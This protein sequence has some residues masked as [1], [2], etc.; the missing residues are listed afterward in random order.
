MEIIEDAAGVRGRET[1]PR[2][3]PLASPV[4]GGELLIKVPGGVAWYIQSM[5]FQFATSAVVA[6]R[7]VTL[8]FGDGSAL[9]ERAPAQVTQA[10]SGNTIYTAATGLGVVQ[11]FGSTQTIALPTPAIPL[12]GGFQITTATS[13]IDVGDQY[14]NIVLYVLEVSETPYD[15]ELARDLAQLRGQT[16]NAYP[17]LRA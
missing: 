12:L 5:R 11:G 3:L 8:E 1:I 4:A 16:S 17:S 9:F 2:V 10:A 15:V 7:L 14:S 13:L 6:T